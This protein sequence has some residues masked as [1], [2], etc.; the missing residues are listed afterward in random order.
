MIPKI[1][2]LPVSIMVSDMPLKHPPCFILREILISKCSLFIQASQLLK[3]LLASD[4][5]SNE[6][7]DDFAQDLSQGI[8]KAQDATQGNHKTAKVCVGLLYF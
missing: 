1:E 4:L 6:Y 2:K 8:K 7:V 3:T 5:S